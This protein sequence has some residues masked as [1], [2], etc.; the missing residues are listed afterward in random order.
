MV[1][2]NWKKMKQNNNSTKKHLTKVKGGNAQY[3]KVGKG[4]NGMEG[5]LGMY[6]RE[7]VYHGVG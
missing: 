2:W 6:I 7:G 4:K 1:I 5:V 3:L